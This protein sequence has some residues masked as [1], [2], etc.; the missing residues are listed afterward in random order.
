MV[1]SL[2][3]WGMEERLTPYRNHTPACAWGYKKPLFFEDISPSKPDCTCPLNAEGYL[4]N[5]L[6]ASGKPKRIQHRGLGSKSEPCRDWN[7]A[8]RILEQWFDW[9]QSIAPDVNVERTNVS[10]AQAVSHWEQFQKNDQKSDSTE[11]NYRVLFYKRLLP[12]CRA[13]RR[14]LLKDFDDA[15]TVKNFYSSW[16][17]LQPERGKGT[18]L[19]SGVPLGTNTRL[20]ELER[21]RTF[22]EYCRNNG[23]ITTNFAKPPHIKL[24]SR[25]VQGKRGF[26]DVEWQRIQTVLEGWQDRYYKA[27]PGRKQRLGTFI[28]A[29]R[30]TGQR[31]SDVTMLG[32]HSIMEDPDG[33]RFIALTQIKTGSF[34]KVPLPDDLYEMLMSLPILGQTDRTVILE[35]RAWTCEYGTQFWFWTAQIP[36]GADKQKINKIVE[37]AAKNWSDDVTAV[38]KKTEEEL[39]AFDCHSTP[40]TFRHTFAIWWLMQ[41]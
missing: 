7:K 25:K 13:N 34:V 5:E 41:R 21:Y 36:K 8:N 29:L 16:C 28:H 37:S 24:K 31:L 23:W 18:V 22:L 1:G 32:P 14:H 20:H 2:L 12:W 38:L 40:H 26:L 30:W 6:A 17:N 27:N 19:N 10:V 35:R 15:L 3:E 11:D 33:R 4:R 39:G 9:G